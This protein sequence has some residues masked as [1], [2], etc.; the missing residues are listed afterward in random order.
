[1]RTSHNVIL[2][3]VKEV[4]CTWTLGYARIIYLLLTWYDTCTSLLEMSALNSGFWQDTSF[5]LPAS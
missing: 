3:Y 1:M 4:L 2:S 5:S